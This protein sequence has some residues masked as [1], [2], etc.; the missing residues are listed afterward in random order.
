[1]QKVSTEVF[2]SFLQPCYKLVET[3]KPI[4]VMH[5]ACFSE[6]PWCDS[7][8]SLKINVHQIIHILQN[9]VITELSLLGYLVV[10]RY[11]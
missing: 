11:R 5:H 7:S 4:A 6:I 9:A 10:Y 3:I 8:C 1:M 2:A